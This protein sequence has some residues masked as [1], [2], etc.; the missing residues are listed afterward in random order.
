MSK[1]Y[2]ENNEAP[3]I[4][5]VR[6]RTHTQGFVRPDG[7]PVDAQL[8]CAAAEAHARVLWGPEVPLQVTWSRAEDTHSGGGEVT[9]RVEEMLSDE[10]PVR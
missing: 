9:V 6:G 8:A 7:E 5:P 10:Q 2:A 1:V 3:K 4:V